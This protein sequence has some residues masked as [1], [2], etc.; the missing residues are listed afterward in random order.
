V[1][2][3]FDYPNKDYG[4]VGEPDR[5]IVGRAHEVMEFGDV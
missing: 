5:R 4:V 1:L 3:R 2:A